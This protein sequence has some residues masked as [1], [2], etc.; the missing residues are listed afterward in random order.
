MFQRT[1]HQVH[2]TI[3]VEPTEED[4]EYK[5]NTA[6]I[7]YTMM[8]FRAIIRKY[9]IELCTHQILGNESQTESQEDGRRAISTQFDALWRHEGAQGI[10]GR[11]RL[12]VP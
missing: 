2:R 10:S 5:V 9:Y 7:S 4:N 3:N 11:I 12:R 1:S 8:D 6:L